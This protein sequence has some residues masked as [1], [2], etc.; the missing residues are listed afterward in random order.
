MAHGPPAEYVTR[1]GLLGIE[2]GENPELGIDS[3]WGYAVR[4]LSGVGWC[5][6]FEQVEAN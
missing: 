1:L 2:G 6:G 5:C 3:R 4:E